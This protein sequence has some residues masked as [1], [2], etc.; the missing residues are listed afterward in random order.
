MAVEDCAELPLFFEYAQWGMNKRVKDFEQ[1][2]ALYFSLTNGQ[3]N[4]T[5][6]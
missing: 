3:R 2:P 4:V 1:V 5:V 6:E